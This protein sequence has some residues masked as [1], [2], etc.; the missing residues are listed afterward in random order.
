MNIERLIGF[1]AAALTT[2]SLLPQVYHSLRTRDTHSISLGM[3]MLFTLG[4]AL[5]LVYGL[6]IHDLPVM[7]ANGVTLVL[8]LVVLGFMLRYG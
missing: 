6:L 5:W 8:T 7:L 3:Y 1:A 2:I 4:V